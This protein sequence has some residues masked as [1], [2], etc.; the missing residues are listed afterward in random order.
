VN[1][2]TNVV[3]TV[4]PNLF[5]RTKMKAPEFVHQTTPGYAAGFGIDI[6]IGKLRLS[7]EFRYTRLQRDNFRSPDGSFHSNLVQPVFL[8][9][10]ER[11]TR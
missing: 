7:P 3:L 10:I 6:K 9:G 4:F 1:E 5:S 8:L 11:A 2:D